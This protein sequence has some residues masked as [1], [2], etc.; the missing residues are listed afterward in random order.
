MRGCR[1]L[2]QSRQNSDGDERSMEEYRA[3]IIGTDG[4]IIRR[5]DLRCPDRGEARR[6]AKK[7]VDGHAVELWQADQ[8]IERFEPGR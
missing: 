2:A 1:Q 6:L 3:Y 4:R 8:F 7:A 5:V